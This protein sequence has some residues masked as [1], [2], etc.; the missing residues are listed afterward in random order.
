[1]KTPELPLRGF[2]LLD[3]LDGRDQLCEWRAIKLS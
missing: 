3:P 1:M 2:Y